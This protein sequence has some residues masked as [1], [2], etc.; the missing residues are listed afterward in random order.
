MRMPGC[1]AWLLPLL[2]LA[3]QLICVSGMYEDQLGTFDW[4]KQLV[5][6]VTHAS[7]APGGDRLF[8]GSTA[9][10]LVAALSK[11]DGSIAWRRTF[12]PADSFGASLTLS[13]PALLITASR[14]GKYV[15]GWDAEGNFKWE[16][17]VVPGLAAAAQ[18]AVALAAAK[19]GGA[20]QQSVLV[21][22]GDQLA[23]SAHC[24]ASHWAL[25][26]C[27]AGTGAHGTQAAAACGPP[28]P[29]AQRSAAPL[30]SAPT[31]SPSPPAARAAD[32]GRGQRHGDVAGGAAGRINS[33]AGAEQHG[34]V[35]DCC[36][37]HP[38]VRAPT[39]LATLLQPA[40]SIRLHHAATSCAWC[41]G[42]WAAPRCCSAHPCCCTQHPS[43][44]KRGGPRATACPQVSQAAGPHL[45]PVGRQPSRRCQPVRPIRPGRRGGG[46]RR[47]RGSAVR[48]RRDAVRGVQRGAGAD[49]PAA[50]A[51]AGWLQSSCLPGA[52][53]A[54]QGGSGWS[55][56][57]WG[58]AG[59]GCA[60]A[61]SRR[62]QSRWWLLAGGDEREGRRDQ[63]RCAAGGGQCTG[64]QGWLIACCVAGRR[65]L[66]ACCVRAA[67]V[68]LLALS[69][70]GVSAVKAWADAT[71]ASAASTDKVPQMVVA[72]ASGA[73]EQHAGSDRNGAMAVRLCTHRPGPPT[74]PPPHAPAPHPPLP[75]HPTPPPLLAAPQARW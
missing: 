57:R 69:S 61:P 27:R 29:P 6:E 48:R 67:G 5:G 33:P 44:L 53:G 71:A 55:G 51:A 18:H 15:R 62:L 26:A 63:G 42:T 36:L 22:A 11:A 3:P 40:Y 38:R 14:G 73:G 39:R 16:A 19:L 23:V 21:A 50:G 47:L 30:C 59:G 70:S 24:G 28:R 12:T 1:S 65:W 41:G 25:A 64:R 10:H 68:L 17:V 58:G 74:A 13:K 7:L 4:Y 49:L 20:A 56:P 60:A 8:V 72:A 9:A 34:P 37:P 45:Q 52:G 32:A 46:Q 35:G 54:R 66:I 75:T 2:L 31:T 43:Q